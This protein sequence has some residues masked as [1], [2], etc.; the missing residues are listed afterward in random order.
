MGNSSDKQPTVKLSWINEPINLQNEKYINY[1]LYSN[2]PCENILKNYETAQQ[3][4]Q[5]AKENK[6]LQEE[7]D[8]FWNQLKQ[9]I[10][11]NADLFTKRNRELQ[12]HL[13]KEN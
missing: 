6:V 9:C 2:S 5:E 11:N 12:H 1:L 3:K 10:L 7:S 8:M 4:L 13:K